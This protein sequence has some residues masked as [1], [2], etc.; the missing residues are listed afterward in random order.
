[1]RLPVSQLAALLTDTVRQAR[2][3]A[4]EL[5]RQG[6]ATIGLEEFMVEV[7]LVPDGGWNKIERRQEETPGK[8]TSS[9]LRPTTRTTTIQGPATTEVIQPAVTSRRTETRTSTES[10][11]TKT[12][13][14]VTRTTERGAAS[15]TST[16]T[17]T[18]ES[19]TEDAKDNRGGDVVNQDYTVS[20][21]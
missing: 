3:A 13:G 12:D 14:P 7:E 6:I 10:R 19:Q 11:V 8:Q 20:A 17:A 5:S 16:K 9:E 18:H 15:Q 1:M 2:D 4:C 21:T